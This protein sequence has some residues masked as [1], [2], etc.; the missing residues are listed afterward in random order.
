MR[1]KT[2][3]QETKS[4]Y[5]QE[6]T[7]QTFTITPACEAQLA[8]IME[9]AE[10]EFTALR[11]FVEG[12]GCNGLSYGMT[13]DDGRTEYDSVRQFEGFQLVV[14]AVALNFLW[15][16]EIDYVKEGLNESF[17]FNNVFESVGGSGMC[18]GCGG[19]GF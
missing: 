12:G 9:E 3:L 4:E 10:E 15:G 6:I 14:D 1:F 18:S 11:I 2:V 7:K 13:Y 19:S 16:C 17:V 5:S 8:N